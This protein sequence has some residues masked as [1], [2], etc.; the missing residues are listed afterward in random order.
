MSPS[1]AI[2]LVGRVRETGSMA[3]AKIG[4][5]RRPI[6]EPHAA[7]VRA[8]ATVK[9]GTTLK[10]IRAGLNARG[11]EVKALSTIADMLHRLGLSHK[12]RVLRAAEQDRPDV[13]RHRARWRVWQRFMDGERFVF[14][15]ETGAATN[16]TRLRGWGPRGERL[17]DAAPHG[18][19]RTT[20]FLAGLKGKRDRRALRARWPDDRGRVQGLCGAD[21]G[22]RPAA[23]RRRGHGQPRR[24][25]GRRVLP[26]PS[27]RSVRA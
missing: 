18:H 1:A 21:A 7:T 10:K 4:G 11:V 24:A 23:R 16:M 20:T 14:L 27:G 2:K 8:L 26:R 19:W 25:Q 3:P 5:H 13:A 9:G 6:L 12:K 22:A 15:D 17:V